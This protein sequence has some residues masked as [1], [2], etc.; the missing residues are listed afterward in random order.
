MLRGFAIRGG[1]LILHAVNVFIKTNTILTSRFALL[2]Q[3]E[4]RYIS[5]EKEEALYERLT[6]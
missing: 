1:T 6:Y 2:K 3:I 4:V 5:K